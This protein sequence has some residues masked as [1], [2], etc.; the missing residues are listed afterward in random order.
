MPDPPPE[1]AMEV[2]KKAYSL[3]SGAEAEIEQAMM[4]RFMSPA[5][6]EERRQRGE[7]DIARII[8]EHTGDPEAERLLRATIEVTQGIPPDKQSSELA[9]LSL[10]IEAHI[11]RLTNERDALQAIVDKLPKT[12]DGVPVVAG[13]DIVFAFV[14]GILWGSIFCFSSDVLF[15]VRCEDSKT[16][17]RSVRLAYSECYSTREAAIAAAEPEDQG[18]ER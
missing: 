12:A 16:G 15:E 14:D 9:D 13:V 6:A 7:A 8:A 11:K 10:S 3:A 4:Q 18:S 5:Q 2:A 17:V 1:Y